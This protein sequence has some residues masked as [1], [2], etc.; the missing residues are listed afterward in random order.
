V[1]SRLPQRLVLVCMAGRGAVDVRC[2][3][4]VRFYDSMVDVSEVEEVAAW[5]P[6][7]AVETRS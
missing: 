4:T 6:W 5:T 3:E 2:F 7:R 1:Q